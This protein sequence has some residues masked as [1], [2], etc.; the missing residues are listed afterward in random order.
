ML[1]MYEGKMLAITTIGWLM[2]IQALGQ[3]QQSQSNRS[4]GIVRSK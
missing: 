3:D 2:H 4:G 1:R